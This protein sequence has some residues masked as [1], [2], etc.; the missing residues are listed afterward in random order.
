M[1]TIP[2][3]LFRSVSRCCRRRCGPT[4]AVVLIKLLDDLFEP[5]NVG[6]TEFNQILHIEDENRKVA[7]PRVVTVCIKRTELL[8]DHLPVRVATTATSFHL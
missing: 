8:E 2:S 1:D 3:T 4:A 7:S 6:L 5:S